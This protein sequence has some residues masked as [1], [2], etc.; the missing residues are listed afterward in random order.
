MYIVFKAID[1]WQ[2]V[3]VNN[4]I[5]NKSI[6]S[7]PV[8]HDFLKMIVHEKN[9]DT[10]ITGRKQ[11]TLTLKKQFFCTNGWPVMVNYWDE[12]IIDMLLIRD[13]NLL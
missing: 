9:R 7:C 4:A 8:E 10:E 3:K 11:K 12:I 5:V 6:F 1:E 13:I 2:L